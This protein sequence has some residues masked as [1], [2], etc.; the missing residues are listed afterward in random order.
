MLTMRGF[1]DIL[2]ISRHKRQHNFSLQFAEF[3]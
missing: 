3:D 2:H 1:C